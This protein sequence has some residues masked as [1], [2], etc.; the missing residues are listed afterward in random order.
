MIKFSLIN[1]F[2]KNQIIWKIRNQK[3][4]INLLNKLVFYKI[5]LKIKSRK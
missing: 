3:K 1:K 5:L 4:M 2:N